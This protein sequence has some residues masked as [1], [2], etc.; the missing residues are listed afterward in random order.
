MRGPRKFSRR[1]AS[2][3]ILGAMVALMLAG[4]A[5]RPGR[6][7]VLICVDTARY[8]VFAHADANGSGDALTS[9]STRAIRFS[10]AWSASSWTV[11]A[12][13]S[14]MTGLYP[15]QH[16]AGMFK[17]AIANVD[18]TLPSGLAPDHTTLFERL[19]ERGYRTAAWADT[20]WLVRM[21]ITQG[22]D[23]L[24]EADS[25]GVL[26]AFVEWTRRQERPFAAYLHL[27]Q[28]HGRHTRPVE[29]LR[30]D[31]AQIPPALAAEW[32]ALAPAG[33][34]A[35]PASDSCAAF[36]NYAA[37]IRTVREQLAIMLAEMEKSGLLA[38]TVVVLFSDHGESFGEHSQSPLVASDPREPV[39]AGR[40][41]GH[42]LFEELLDVPLYVWDSRQGGAVVDAPASII[43]IVPMSLSL[44]GIRSDERFAG[45]T[46]AEM[47]QSP[48]RAL[49]ASTIAYGG[50]QTA[51]RIGRWK[52]IAAA[53]PPLRLT[54]DLQADPA[55]ERP[56]TGAP[57]QRRL[58]V[59]L[60]RLERQRVR[61]GEG[62]VVDAETRERLR[63]LG[64]LTGGSGSPAPAP[65]VPQLPQSATGERA[66][67]SQ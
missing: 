3:P 54:F 35:D 58:D 23:T 61:A 15:V 27:M 52:R 41:H 13:S 39:H 20:P 65:C 40:G 9:W 28:V 44:L 48:E 38:N 50:D 31:A 57:L 2:S 49:F 53:C 63:S 34:C 30:R 4:C 62:V 45:R 59:E 18:N 26:P 14:A 66:R 43:D 29:E 24:T 32:R 12:V 1:A 17:S 46:L 19:R 64:Y 36:L 16:G 6:N 37:S 55:E 56:V 7:F 5:Q 33:A 47:R 10:D 8:D 60:A 42:G 22:I 67:T 11:P 51:V 21:G 25:A